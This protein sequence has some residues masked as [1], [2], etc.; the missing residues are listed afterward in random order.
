MWGMRRERE[1]DKELRFHIESQIEENLRA[2]MSPAEARRQALLTF[3][4]PAQIREE[5]RELRSLFW[6]GTLWA[7][8][9][10]AVRT[11]RA[12]LA[13][14]FS[15]VVSIALGIG[16][17]AAIFTL[18]HAALWKPLPVPRPGELFQAVR[19]DGVEQ[20]WS[21]SWPLYKEL[22]DAVA[23]YGTVFARGSAGPRRFSLGGAEPERVIGEAVTPEYFSALEVKP[24]AGRLMDHRDEETRQP[25][26]VISHKFWTTRL[27]GDLSVI[28]KI[29]QYD[30]APFHIIGVAQPEFNGVDAG[31]ATDIWVPTAVVDSRFL[32]DG[33]SSNW[34]T[35]MLR[36][37][38]AKTA[39]AGIEA[40]F[41]RHVLE[42]LMPRATGQRYQKSLKAQH[43]RLRP[44]ASGLASLGRP[45]ERALLVLM[46]IVGLVLLISCANVANLI[47]A[48]NLSRQQEI[49][50]RMALGAGRARL[51]SQLLKRKPRA[52]SGGSGGGPAARN[53]RMPPAASIVTGGAHS[54]RIGPAAGC[55]G[56]CVHGAR[57]DW[58][59]IT[60]WRRPR[61]ARVAVGCG[62]ASPRRSTDYRPDVWA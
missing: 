60:V 23:P 33:N 57:G 1:L 55:H 43:I 45:Y 6:L 20:N 29:I 25:V 16:A 17:N 7:D 59:G 27:R 32:S 4:G 53:G 47:L 19:S 28:G 11:L 50:V 46:G 26:A 61:V 35:L 44:A 24:F 41:Q 9:R 14:S 36:A 48:R 58:Y 39:Q 38:D 40:R 54:S 10:Y 3:G 51:A 2:G 8:V 15:A 62:R 30:E 22:Q 31:I 13:F 12:S 21:Y 52:V 49:A 18:L 56:A 34:L 37:H 5:C 42:E